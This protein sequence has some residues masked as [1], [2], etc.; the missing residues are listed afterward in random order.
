VFKNSNYFLFQQ[1]IDSP[2]KF[3]SIDYYYQESK[4]KR[5]LSRLRDG[6]EI[7]LL[8]S[9]P[10]IEWVQEQTPKKRIKRDF[11]D[12]EPSIF[13]RFQRK[14]NFA[15]DQDKNKDGIKFNDPM[16]SKLWYIEKNPEP[17][18]RVEF[19]INSDK[20]FIK[21]ETIQ[22]AYFDKNAWLISKEK[23]QSSIKKVEKLNETFKKVIN[24]SRSLLFI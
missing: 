22:I 16:W 14:R 1:D 21:E 24:S 10:S 23:F 17:S 18:M 3:D 15:E 4:S 20:F 11:M 7:R 8:E 5:G 19:V 12:F 2:D 13:S 9:D 6:A